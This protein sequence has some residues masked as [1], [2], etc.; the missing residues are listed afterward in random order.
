MKIP[1][2][3]N[4][5]INAVLYSEINLIRVSIFLLIF[6]GDA[7]YYKI[8]FNVIYML[9]IILKKKKQKRKNIEI[10]KKLLCSN[11]KQFGFKVRKITSNIIVDV[12]CVFMRSKWEK[13]K[14]LFNYLFVF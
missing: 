1:W 12:K 3:N 7:F 11:N 8:Q 4:D 9:Q 6:L 10:Y 5:K 14:I 13:T 2:I